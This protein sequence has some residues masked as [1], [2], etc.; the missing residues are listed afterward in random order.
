MHKAHV[1]ARAKL[2]II[3][4]EQFGEPMIYTSSEHVENNKIIW[5]TTVT[6]KS[7]HIINGYGEASTKTASKEIAAQNALDNLDTS[8]DDVPALSQE[9]LIITTNPEKSKS[10]KSTKSVDEFE[11]ESE[12]EKQLIQAEFVREHA[13]SAMKQQF[14]SMLLETINTMTDVFDTRIELAIVEATHKEIKPSIENEV[15]K[16]L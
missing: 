3:C 8:M 9:P 7:A 13:I 1:T 5:K 11:V 14:K 4:K 2:N 12:F 6:H 15:R 16:Q 10:Q